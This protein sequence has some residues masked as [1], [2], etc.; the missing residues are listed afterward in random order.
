[1]QI[2][3]AW[4]QAKWLLCCDGRRVRQYDSASNIYFAPWGCQCCLFYCGDYVV[5]SSSFAV[6]PT[7]PPFVFG[8]GLVV[9][10]GKMAKISKR[11]I[12]VPHL[13]QDTT[14]ESNKNT[15]IITNKSQ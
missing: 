9:K 15:I 1:M 8:T 6:A 4:I 14:Q 12:Q 3:W 7:P 13:T 11:Y 10:V 5:V 2:L